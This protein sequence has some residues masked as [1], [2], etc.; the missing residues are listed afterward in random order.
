MEGV[1]N[2]I[3]PFVWGLTS[4]AVASGVAYFY[5]SFVTA[6]SRH[7]LKKISLAPKDIE[8]QIWVPRLT[9]LTRVGMVALVML[10]YGFF[11]WGTLRAIDTMAPG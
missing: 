1:L 4:A 3:L 7:N 9:N 2:A 8:P 10:A 5:Q 11:L 6:K